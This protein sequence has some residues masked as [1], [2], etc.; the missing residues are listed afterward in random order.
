MVDVTQWAR[1]AR[2]GERITY[3]SGFTPPPEDI[4]RAAYRAHE[5][6]L[7]FLCQRRR[8][9][10]AGGFDYEAQR[11]SETTFHRL[12][13]LWQETISVPDFRF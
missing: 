12:R 5:Q 1:G 7:V 8:T 4:A 2:P 13:R 11:I 9:S 6:R 3:H 10:R